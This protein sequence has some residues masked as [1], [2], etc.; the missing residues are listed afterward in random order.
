MSA[1]AVARDPTV[2]VFD[3]MMFGPTCSPSLAQFVKN[4]HAMKFREE[5]PE[6]VD[7]L[8]NFTYVDDYFNS[9]PTIEEALKVTR[10]AISICDKMGLDL[11]G[12]QSNSVELLNRLPEKSRK[13]KLVSIDPYDGQGGNDEGSRHVLGHR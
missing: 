8:I 12:V 7:A 9:H 3:R 2:Y 13:A 6:A 10:D 4:Q 5:C 11:R 1:N